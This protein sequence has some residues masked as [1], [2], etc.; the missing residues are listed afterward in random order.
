MLNLGNFNYIIKI[1]FLLNFF[2]F[3]R[4]HVI[5]YISKKW[6]LDIICFW[7]MSWQGNGVLQLSH[8]LWMIEAPGQGCQQLH[9]KDSFSSPS[10][11]LKVN[12]PK[13]FLPLWK[14]SLSIFLDMGTIFRLYIFCFAN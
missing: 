9:L 3:Y 6:R 4:I 10:L 8:S 1:N 7:E 5:N 13:I 2:L 11:S 12:G 14:N